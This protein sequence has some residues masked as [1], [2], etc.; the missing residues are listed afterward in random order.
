MNKYVCYEG[1]GHIWYYMNAKI[2]EELTNSIY[3]VKYEGL[4]YD[5][6]YGMSYAK[7]NSVF[8]SEEEAKDFCKNK[9]SIN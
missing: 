5:G 1:Q 3:S 8:D 6:V 4:F 9:N 7:H 2:V